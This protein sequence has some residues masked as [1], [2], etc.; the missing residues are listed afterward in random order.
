VQR[1]VL[2][3]PR[4]RHVVEEARRARDA[5]E[6]GGIVE[7]PVSAASVH[8]MREGGRSEVIGRTYVG[9]DQL[10][11]V[12]GQLLRLRGIGVRARRA[13]EPRVEG[14]AEVQ[15]R[16][17]RVW[18]WCRLG[19][20]RWVLGVRRRVWHGLGVAVRSG[21]TCVTGR[22]ARSHIVKHMLTNGVLWCS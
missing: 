3:Q 1:D 17:G 20:P 7:L 14:R 4:Q 15:R 16:V 12:Q 2:V 13:R 10:D 19:G 18:C 6:V 11:E 22:Q 8:V 9:E 21:G 5:R